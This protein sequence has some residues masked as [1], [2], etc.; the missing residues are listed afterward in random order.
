VNERERDAA[1][2]V[3]GR[4]AG[5][6]AIVT[7]GASGIGRGIVEVFARESARVLIADIDEAARDVAREVGERQGTQVEF[8]PAD[9]T[10][11][12]AIARLMTAAVARFGGVH[13]L[14][15]NAGI[16]PPAALEE[17]TEADWD[18]VLDTNLKSAFLL[19]KACS[20]L[21]SA[22]GW[23]RIVFTSSITGPITGIPRYT[24]Y[25]ASKAGLLGFVRN[26]AVELAG[27]NITV[28][29]V[30][31][32]NILTPGMTGL[33]ED[34]IERQTE[35]IPLR[36]LGSPEDVAHA[37]LFLASD[38]ASYITGQGIVVDGG[39]TLPEA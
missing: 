17:M 12:D 37:M 24:H 31:P 11:A 32:G 39:Q 15:H 34:Y 29:A 7:G 8:E 35:R 23:G 2:G 22:G 36:R 13:I 1:A 20:P 3:S 33:G 21:M 18:R 19:V 9:I 26:A 16:Y 10:S 4:L 14:C 6:S 30:L 28:N 5:R 25:G 27:D 38:E